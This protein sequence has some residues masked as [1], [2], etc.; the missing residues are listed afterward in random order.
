MNNFSIS[1]E[2]DLDCRIFTR[3]IHG[4]LT[5]YR[6]KKINKFIRTFN[7][8]SRYPY[9]ISKNGYAYTCGCSHDCCGCLSRQRM[10][11]EFNQNKI[12]ITW[13]QSFNY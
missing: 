9:G 10:D 6:Y 11:M 3:T 2:S 1:S 12:T 4:R 13:T 8:D 5:K 7:K